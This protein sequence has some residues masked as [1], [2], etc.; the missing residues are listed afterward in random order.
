[1]KDLEF[2]LEAWTLNTIYDKVINC[3]AI[4]PTHKTESVSWDDFMLDKRLWLTWLHS[5][6]WQSFYDDIIVEKNKYYYSKD[7]TLWNSVI[8]NKEYIPIWTFASRETNPLK[9]QKGRWGWWQLILDATQT[10]NNLAPDT[11]PAD[12]ASEITN[13]YL[14]WNWGEWLITL[15]VPWNWWSLTTSRYIT[16]TTWPLKWCTNKILYAVWDLVYISG[17]DVY[18]SLPLNDDKYYIFSDERETILIWTDSWLTVMSLTDSS[19]VSKFYYS[20]ILT[21][22]ILD[23]FTINIDWIKLLLTWTNDIE[24]KAQLETWLWTWYKIEIVNWLLYIYRLD[25]LE[26]IFTELNCLTIFDLDFL[27]SS[28]D[29]YIDYPWVWFTIWWIDKFYH[30]FD[31]NLQTYIERDW[32]DRAEIYNKNAFM[33]MII[34]DL[35]AWYTWIKYNIYWKSSLYTLWNISWN[36]KRVNENQKWLLIYKDDLTENTV[37]KYNTYW[38]KVT[39]NDMSSLPLD[40]IRV[41][42][43]WIDY[44]IDRWWELTSPWQVMEEITSLFSWLWYTIYKKYYDNTSYAWYRKQDWKDFTLSITYFWTYANNFDSVTYINLLDYNVNKNFC[45]WWDWITVSYWTEAVKS[46]SYNQSNTILNVNETNLYSYE[47][48]HWEIIDWKQELNIIDVVEF[49]WAIFVLT[50]KA[51]Y[52]SR[53]T[54]WDNTHFCPLDFFSY[55]WWTKLIP[56]WQALIVIWEQ[57]KVITKTTSTLLWTEN[58]TSYLMKDLDFDWNLFSKYSYIY[59]EW[60]LYFLQDDKRLMVITVAPW[61]SVTY[62]LDTQEISKSYRYLFDSDEWECFINKYKQNLNFIFVNW[63]TTKNFQYDISL[64]NWIINEY[65]YPIYKIADNIL[66]WAKDYISNWYIA[67]EEWYT[68]FWTAFKQVIN[69]SYWNLIKLTQT[70]ILRTIFGL[71]KTDRLDVKLT[72]EREEAS[73]SMI[74]TEHLLNNY[75]F[76][77]MLDPAPDWD[78][79]IWYE[80]QAMYNGNLASIQTDIYTA[81]RY[82]RFKLESETRFIMSSNYLIIRDMKAIINDILTSN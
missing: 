37:I 80:E 36:Y 59:T 12:P 33:D 6:I 26:I 67:I 69:F 9:L 74:T 1:M 7:L 65:D 16:F 27:Q 18:W 31:N 44:D 48:L 43:D 22:W 42:I 40:T 71:T 14:I 73:W 25:E 75:S 45:Y 21:Y 64:Q 62:R 19:E 61:D 5:V 10:T 28:I 70:S 81:W 78:E 41:T 34:N 46:E 79:L 49:E 82:T 30:T 32:S 68:D 58:I 63:N 60:T 11:N 47:A 52:F 66:T 20:I 17:T 4:K 53:V 76:D 13:P 23:Y 77:T 50:D 51:I 38:K 15:N 56:F 54:F 8:Y 72:V 35:P 29:K 57:N 24:T 2:K 39:M 3:R 55:K